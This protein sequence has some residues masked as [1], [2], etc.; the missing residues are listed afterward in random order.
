M[1]LY[2]HNGTVGEEEAAG[3][4]RSRRRAVDRRL[5][6]SFA[7]QGLAPAAGVDEVGR[8]SLAGP[9]VAAAVILPPKIRLHP[10]L[11]DSK[12]LVPHRRL[13]V[14]DWILALPG[15]SYGI[16]FASVEEVDRWNVLGATMLAMGRSLRALADRPGVVLVDGR[17]APLMEMPVRTIVGGDR[18]CAAIAA[19]SVLAKVTRDRWMN[20]IDRDHPQF[21]FARHKGYGTAGHWEALRL[22]G[23]TSLH[24]R[25]FLGR[26]PEAETPNL[27]WEERAVDPDGD[28]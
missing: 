26:L 28:E 7:R 23:V 22:H 21:G 13:A 14:C 15:I 11:D 12:R 2:S 16:G 19:A 5:E 6:R 3:K 1:R 8:G 9:I 27:L 10:W 25:S 18:R 24:R 17:E 20:D 4:A